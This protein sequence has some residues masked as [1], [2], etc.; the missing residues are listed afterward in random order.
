MPSLVAKWVENA[1]LLQLDEYDWQGKRLK[2]LPTE[3]KR[4]KIR[5][6][7]CSTQKS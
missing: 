2:Y 5:W 3:K 4:Q 6:H 1:A 7:R